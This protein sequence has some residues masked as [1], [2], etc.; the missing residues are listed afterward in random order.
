[1]HIDKFLFIL[2]GGWFLII[3]QGVMAYIDGFCTHA[4]V[5]RVRKIYGFG[6]S[7]IEHG[8]MWSDFFMISPLTAYIVS[9]YA[10]AY[11]SNLSLLLLFG[12]FALWSLLSIFVYAPYGAENP[13]A[14][15]HGGRV[16]TAGWIHVIYATI[17][18]WIIAMI[19][20]PSMTLSV[21]SNEDLV[22]T[23]LILSIWAYMG[24]KKF[25]DNWTFDNGAKIQVIVEVIVIWFITIWLIY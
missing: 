14:H 9:K 20:I 16:T 3:A 11:N 15:A 1:M 22:I 25:S 6:Y 10:F 21:V 18:T 5:L 19:Y 23:S 2:I 24:V 13:E 17:S 4:Q 12:I 7:F 8:G